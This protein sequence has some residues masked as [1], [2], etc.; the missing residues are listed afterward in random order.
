MN[1]VEEQ[2]SL[3]AS[4]NLQVESTISKLEDLDFATAVTELN[5]QLVALEAAQQTYIKT[6]GISLFNYL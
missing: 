2:I 6:Q 4:F 1:R 3:N 5:L